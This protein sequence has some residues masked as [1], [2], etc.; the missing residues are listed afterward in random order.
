MEPGGLRV[1]ALTGE[2]SCTWE[3]LARY[4]DAQQNTGEVTLRDGDKPFLAEATP[5][6]PEQYWEAIV[7]Q[8]QPP[9]F[10][11]CHEKPSD[12]FCTKG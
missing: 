6:S 4:V 2:L 3:I 10:H 1:S 7:Y 12:Y 8:G 5:H 9:Y 11:P